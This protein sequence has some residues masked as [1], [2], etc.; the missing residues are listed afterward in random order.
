M[1]GLWLLVTSSPDHHIFF[2]LICQ[3]ELFYDVAHTC[4]REERRTSPHRNNPG[5]S[6]EQNSEPVF[7]N[8]STHCVNSN[9]IRMWSRGN[10]R[11]QIPDQPD[12]KKL[13]RRR[14]RH[15]LQSRKLLEQMDD[16]E[17]KTEGR[18]DTSSLG[19]DLQRWR[20]CKQSR[21]Q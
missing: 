12:D 13:N 19:E 6:A 2:K 17:E 20:S 1:N 9:R 16:T 3:V 11:A 7:S 15:T 5:N 10:H 21:N 8:R 14:S 18:G 4:Q